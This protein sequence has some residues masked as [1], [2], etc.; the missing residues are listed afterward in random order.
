MKKIDMPRTKPSVDVCCAFGDT[1]DVLQLLLWRLLLHHGVSF[2]K[3]R[4]QSAECR[5]T[6]VCTSVFPIY[7]CFQ[8]LL[9]LQII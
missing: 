7:L 9:Q 2:C 8:I 6:N 5:E 1:F 3:L 4:V